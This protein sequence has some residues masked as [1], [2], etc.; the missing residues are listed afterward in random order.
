MTD[1]KAAAYT[2]LYTV[3]VTLAKLTAP[4][5]P[6]MAEQMYLNLVPQFFPKEPKSVHLCS[7]PVSD[8]SFI[9]ETLEK[10]MDE[11]TDIVVLG[12]AA[13]NAGNLKNRQPL[14]EMV[15]VS[16]R[17]ITL[18]KEEQAIVLE[19]LNVKKLTSATDA[20]KYITYKIKPQLKTLGPKYGK[21]LGAIS[22]FLAKC[23]AE[24]VVAAV[25]NGGV[26]TLPTD[27]DLTLAMFL[28]PIKAL[29]LPFQPR[30]PK[31]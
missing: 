23:N 20:S 11:V 27:S 30:L 31:S 22:A 14:A 25:K 26:F 7:F 9:D 21:K 13:R 1:D 5:T 12:R 18:S 24:E 10:A 4:Y 19:E 2:T 29:R 6:F 8:S 16:D 17:N 28:P 15:V 3:L